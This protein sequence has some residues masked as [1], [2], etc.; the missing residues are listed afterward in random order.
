MYQTNNNFKYFNDPSLLICG[1]K[2][3][4]NEGE[5]VKFLFKWFRTNFSL[6]KKKRVHR[7]QHESAGKKMNSSSTALAYYYFQMNSNIGSYCI[8]SR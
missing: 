6:C 1:Q 4:K 3:N 8:V 5:N 7:L 2:T